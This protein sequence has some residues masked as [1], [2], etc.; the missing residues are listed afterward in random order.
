MC[1]HSRPGHLFK[2]EKTALPVDLELTLKPGGASP[3]PT[4]GGRAISRNGLTRG[5]GRSLKSTRLVK[6]S[7]SSGTCRNAPR[8]CG[9]RL[10]V[11]GD[12]DLDTQHLFE[13]KDSIVNGILDSVNC[14]TCC[15]KLSDS[16]EYSS[17]HSRKN[18]EDVKCFG[19]V[20]ISRD[21]GRLRPE[22]SCL[23]R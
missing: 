7:S 10:A 17:K 11:V 15:E 14:V 6:E 3:G 1:F 5:G 9:C 16:V 23:F 18:P 8:G 12:C 22:P 21:C 2:A 20:A 13:P 4:N 19:R